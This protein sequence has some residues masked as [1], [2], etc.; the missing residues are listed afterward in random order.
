M[1]LKENNFGFRQ[2]FNREF[3]SITVQTI[4]DFTV[5]RTWNFDNGLL[6]ARYRMAQRDLCSQTLLL[7]ISATV[8]LSSLDF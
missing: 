6:F 5:S 4:N 2:A 3:C 7:S 1:I 8:E